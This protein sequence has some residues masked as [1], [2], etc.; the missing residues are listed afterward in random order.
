MHNL[1]SKLVENPVK[2]IRYLLLLQ[3][4]NSVYVFL[5]CLLELD[6]ILWAGTSQSIPPVL[7]ELEVNSIMVFLNAEDSS[8]RTMV[9]LHLL[10][11]ISPHHR[12]IDN[13]DN[14][15]S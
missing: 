12:K 3:E 7:D 10:L 11:L 15:Q 9:C 5:A 6:P 14:V 2:K 13:K 4:P 8:H 1:S